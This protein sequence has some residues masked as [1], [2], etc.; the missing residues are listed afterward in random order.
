MGGIPSFTTLGTSAPRQIFCGPI[1][2]AQGETRESTL[3]TMFAANGAYV[4]FPGNDGE[5]F[6]DPDFLAK[7]PPRSVSVF[8]Q[9]GRRPVYVVCANKDDCEIKRSDLKTY[10]F[11][12]STATEH[13]K[14]FE[15]SRTVWLPQ[16]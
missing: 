4:S 11:K 6:Q 9:K 16:A 14:Y 1:L 3:S 10:G 2:P 12:P 7:V 15:A 13:Y 5:G 8:K